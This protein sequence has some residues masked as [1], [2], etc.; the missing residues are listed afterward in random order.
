M[1]CLRLQS[2]IQTVNVFPAMNQIKSRP[3]LSQ[4]QLIDYCFQHNIRVTAYSP[5]GSGSLIG[6]P[7]LVDIGKK[8]EKSSAQV[9]IRWQI[10][11][12]VVAIPKSTKRDRLRDNINVFDFS[13]TEQEMKTIEEM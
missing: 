6:N 12:G 11:R 13:L 7:T 4:R 3:Q 1:H 9:M 5:L 2:L 10:Q 8:Y